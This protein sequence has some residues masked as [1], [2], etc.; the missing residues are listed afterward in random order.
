M[1]SKKDSVTETNKRKRVDHPSYQRVRGSKFLS[2]N[3]LEEKEG[4]WS[5][6]ETVV[7]VVCIDTLRRHA[8]PQTVNE[9]A[10]LFNAVSAT[11]GNVSI[12]KKACR[13]IQGK[14]KHMEERMKVFNKQ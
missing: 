2:G 11:E 1:Q 7:L 4:R 3:D 6:F 8:L 10:A 9:I 14:L 5:D 12:R 13:Q